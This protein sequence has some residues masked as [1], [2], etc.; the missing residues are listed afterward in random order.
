MCQRGNARQCCVGDDV[1]GW[2]GRFSRNLTVGNP[3]AD[4]NNYFPQSI[5]SVRSRDRLKFMAFGQG[6][7]PSKYVEVAVLCLFIIL[8][9]SNTLML[10]TGRIGRTFSAHSGSN[11]VVLPKKV[12]LEGY[13]D[14]MFCLRGLFLPKIRKLFIGLD[15]NRKTQKRFRACL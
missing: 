14:N 4:R 8:L 3:L 5:M 10:S 9:F 12:P 13:N 2:K 1:S 6:I 11:D 15:G 7:S